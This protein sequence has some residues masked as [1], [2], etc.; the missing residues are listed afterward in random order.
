M[1]K[2]FLLFVL[3][4]LFTVKVNAQFVTGGHYIGPHIWFLS[5]VSILG[6]N[7]EYGAMNLG[8]GKLGIGA[9]ADFYGDEVASVIWLGATGLYHFNVS[10]EFDPFAGLSLY[11]VNVSYKDGFTTGGASSGI[12]WDLYAGARY[13]F[14]PS[15]A[16]NGTL[17]LRGGVNLRG[18]VDFKL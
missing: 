11:N 3:S 13:F 15:I 18:G 6:G 12:Q 1:K 2:L 9:F 16:L 14:T 10:K 7:Y 5:G 8:P 17:S 4:I